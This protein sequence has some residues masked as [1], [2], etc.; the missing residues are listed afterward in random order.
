MSGNCCSRI[1]GSRTR[2][3]AKP[4][5]LHPWK[6]KQTCQKPGEVFA[7]RRRVDLNLIGRRPRTL[8]T[9]HSNGRITLSLRVRENRIK[10][11]R[12]FP[13]RISSTAKNPS[14]HRRRLSR[15]V[16]RPKTLLR[17][18]ITLPDP[19]K[20]GGSVQVFPKRCPVY[21]RIAD[22]FAGNGFHKLQSLPDLRGRTVEIGI[23]RKKR[24]SSMTR[25]GRTVGGVE[26]SG[27]SVG[28]ADQPV[29]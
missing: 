5:S 14:R 1:S 16:P 17:F 25:G 20:R 23:V 6:R 8:Q 29:P 19:L 3:P 21:G 12:K 11:S 13:A 10:D 26:M 24:C 18:L 7:G 4:D 9:S 15:S 27:D 22:C 2:P 28:R